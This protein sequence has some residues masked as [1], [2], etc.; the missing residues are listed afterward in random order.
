MRAVALMEE[1]PTEVV[2]MAVVLSTLVQE[3]V[4]EVQAAVAESVRARIAQ[5]AA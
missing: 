4:G 3:V 5:H 1:V 2:H